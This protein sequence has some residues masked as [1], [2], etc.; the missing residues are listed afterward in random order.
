MKLGLTGGIACGKSTVSDILVRHGAALVDAD[1]IARQVVAPGQPALQELVNQFGTAILTPDGVLHRKRLA[2]LIFQHP[3][4]RKV[5]ESIL[6]PPIR[7]QMKSQI[8][9]IEGN[10]PHQLIVVVIPL[11]YESNLSPIADEV[12]VVYIPEA[13]QRERLMARDQLSFEQADQRIRAQMS[14]EIKKQKADVVID[15]QGSLSQTQSQIIAWLMK[16]GYA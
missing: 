1:V 11:L 4:Q 10:Y 8:K 3:E 6:H 16:K 14:I 12:M 7:L 5:V 9:E 13:L 15:N 2:E